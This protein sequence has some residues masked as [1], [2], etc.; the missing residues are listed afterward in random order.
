MPTL[1]PLVGWTWIPSVLNRSKI[2][3]LPT[4]ADAAVEG[5]MPQPVAAKSSTYAITV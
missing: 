5:R 4:V 1:T 2:A 3:T